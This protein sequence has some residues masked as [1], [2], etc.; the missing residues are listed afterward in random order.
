[1]N[2]NKGERKH[3]H[4]IRYDSSGG[5]E[6]GDDEWMGKIRY[7]SKVI[8]DSNNEIEKKLQEKLNVAKR[9]TMS[10]IVHEIDNNRTK[11][12][13]GIDKKIERVSNDLKEELVQIKQKLMK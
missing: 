4:L 9:D 12:Q 6:G 1:M 5:D 3:L 2:K 11:I 13:N 8:Q 7:L 10:M